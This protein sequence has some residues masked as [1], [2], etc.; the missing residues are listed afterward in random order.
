MRYPSGSSIVPFHS[1]A[2][3]PSNNTRSK[4][5]NSITFERPDQF[6]TTIVHYTNDV[7]SVDTTHVLAIT[8]S[9]AYSI[10]VRTGII[11]DSI[12]TKVYG[13]VDG[14]YAIGVFGDS[15]AMFSIPDFKT[16]RIIAGKDSYGT[17][18]FHRRFVATAYEVYDCRSQELIKHAFSPSF[19]AS[20]S[21]SIVI[22]DAVSYEPAS[23]SH[24]DITGVWTENQY[25]DGVIL[26]VAQDPQ[27]S[28]LYV[29]TKS[30]WNSLGW[31]YLGRLYRIV[32]SGLHAF[33][34]Y[35]YSARIGPFRTIKGRH[36]CMFGE[37]LRSSTGYVAFSDTLEIVRK[38]IFPSPNSGMTDQITQY[39]FSD[40]GR[41]I[42]IRQRSAYL[43]SCVYR[44][45]DAQISAGFIAGT[46]KCLAADTLYDEGQCSNGLHMPAY[47]VSLNAPIIAFK[48]DSLELW[49]VLAERKLAA[50]MANTIKSYCWSDKGTTLRVVT[51]EGRAFSLESNGRVTEVPI[52]IK[53]VDVNFT[54][55][56]SNDGRILTCWKRDTLFSVDVVTGRV[57][58]D[59]TGAPWLRT[60]SYPLVPCISVAQEDGTVLL[61]MPGGSYTI[62]PGVRIESISTVAEEEDRCSPTLRT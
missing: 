18:V 49:D 50:A 6:V 11:Q 41:E 30:T 45:P 40:D 51:E 48:R 33:P 12:R 10:D 36:V 62:L 27:D 1:V 31:G 59:W 23:F 58:R 13:I 34:P 15:I 52:P 38:I 5:D 14:T 19:Y 55:A 53:S 29:S 24:R 57:V 60:D 25:I 61:S 21:G 46:R 54:R 4:S 42:E 20:P 28:A 9:A 47:V 32:P 17:A 44:R 8:D 35:F 43:D 16:V 22:C 39:V 37:T 26:S 3:R 56:W 7:V 2:G